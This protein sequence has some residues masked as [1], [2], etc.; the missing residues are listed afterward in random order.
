MKYAG[1]LVG[2]V[3]V[4]TTKANTRE[5]RIAIVELGEP[6]N[7]SRLAASSL[8]GFMAEGGEKSS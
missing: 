1:N 2:D 6:L 4:M 8:L 3:K 5:Q 7:S